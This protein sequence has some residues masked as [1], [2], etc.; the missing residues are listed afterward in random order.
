MLLTCSVALL[1]ITGLQWR[2]GSQVTLTCEKNSSLAPLPGVPGSNRN[3]WRLGS[4]CLNPHFTDFGI[5]TLTGIIEIH[6]A[7]PELLKR[8]T[9]MD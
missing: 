1:S 6:K 3:R 5:E 7:N 2:T 4:E 9:S 8:S